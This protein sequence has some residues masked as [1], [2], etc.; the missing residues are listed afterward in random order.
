MHARFDAS[1]SVTTAS[2]A[3]AA[4]RAPRAFARVE[5]VVQIG[6]RHRVAVERHDR[7]REMLALVGLYPRLDRAATD[8]RDH[9]C[10][11]CELRDTHGGGSYFSR[12]NMRMLFMYS[13]SSPGL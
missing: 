1:S 6:R 2:A 11:N 7:I 9:T 5:H 10:Q 13:F 3:G 8:C 12:N 4:R